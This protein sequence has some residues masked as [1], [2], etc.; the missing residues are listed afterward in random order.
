MKF[1]VRQLR[2]AEKRYVQG[3]TLYIKQHQKVSKLK[4]LNYLFIPCR[5]E[6]LIF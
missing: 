6:S 3:Y 2:Q 5:F 1:C 4:D